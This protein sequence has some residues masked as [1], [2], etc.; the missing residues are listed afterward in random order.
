M[1]QFRIKKRIDK[2][3]GC[4]YRKNPHDLYIRLRLLRIAALLGSEKSFLRVF[5]FFYPNKQIL[6]KIV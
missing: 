1:L 4:A 6:L 5:L 3:V 2:L